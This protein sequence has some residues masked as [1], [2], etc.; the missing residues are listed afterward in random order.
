MLKTEM[1]DM[2]IYFFG[3]FS[4]T[5]GSRTLSEAHG[6]GDKQ[7]RLIKYLILNRNRPVEKRELIDAVFGY[8]AYSQRTDEALNA[9]NATVHR[10]RKLMSRLSQESSQ[11]ISYS[12]GAYRVLLPENCE[13]DSD[14]FDLFSEKVFSS[15]NISEIK[16]YALKICGIYR[17]FFLDRS[18]SEEWARVLA[19]KYHTSYKRIFCILCGVLRREGNFETIYTL[20]ERASAIDPICE[21]FRFERLRALYESGE[22]KRAREIYLQ[23][24]AFFENTLSVPLSERF[25][26]LGS[27]LVDTDRDISNLSERIFDRRSKFITV[28]T[29]LFE[30]YA[31]FTV[32][33]LKKRND[34]NIHLAEAEM[35]Q[36]LSEEDITL[37]RH[38]LA[39][40]TEFAII[41]PLKSEKGFYL[42]FGSGNIEASVISEEIKRIIV[43]KAVKIEVLSV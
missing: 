22:R 21:D 5:L 40:L 41:S 39:P 11:M 33:T 20:S 37:L 32:G 25:R 30:E 38:A 12:N 18:F 36:E 27:K 1:N 4:L 26:E 14:M 7:W 2:K 10:A 31:S 42:L 13:I 17:G 16:S 34:I 29:D 3:P 15:D 23:M 43:K 9:L 28:P 19:E 24:L 8:G 6:K 35:C